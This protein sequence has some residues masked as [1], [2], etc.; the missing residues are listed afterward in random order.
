MVQ[1]MME[2][3]A[4]LAIVSE[5]YHIPKTTKWIGDE[6]GVAH[7]AIVKGTSSPAALRIKKGRS[8]VMAKIE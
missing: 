8:F 6:D 4:I 3:R 5:P 7:T 2:N 1:T